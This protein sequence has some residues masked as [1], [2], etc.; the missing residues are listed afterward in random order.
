MHWAHSRMDRPDLPR[1]YG[2]GSPGMPM[3]VCS[4]TPGS[5]Q[6]PWHGWIRDDSS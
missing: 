1:S 3:D 4:G 5:H 2:W 6:S